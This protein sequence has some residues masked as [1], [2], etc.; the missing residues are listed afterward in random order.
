M[1]GDQF[2]W[3]DNPWVTS[4]LV[5]DKEQ[6]EQ[7]EQRALEAMGR[8]LQEF[9]SGMSPITMP[10]GV[11][12]TQDVAVVSDVLKLLILFLPEPQRGMLLTMFGGSKDREE[13]TG[14]LLDLLEESGVDVSSFIPDGE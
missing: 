14:Q 9:H 10:A 7:E 13:A 6:R 11:T 2:N 5:Y 8:R 12:V 4:D 1:A 3:L